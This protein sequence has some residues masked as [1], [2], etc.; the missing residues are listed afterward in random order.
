MAYNLPC[1][2]KPFY[3]ASTSHFPLSLSSVTNSSWILGG[4]EATA[5]HAISLLPPAVPCHNR[6]AKQTLGMDCWLP[7]HRNPILPHRVGRSV[8]PGTK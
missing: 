6:K 8:H 1:L 3:S 7:L 2:S 4:G 5:S